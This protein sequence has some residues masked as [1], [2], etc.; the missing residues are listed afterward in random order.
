M[1]GRVNQWVLKVG[2]VLAVVVP[3]LFAFYT[4]QK[5]IETSQEIEKI[6]LARD[7]VKDFYLEE[8]RTFRNIRTA[9]ESCE[10]LY[11]EYKKGGKFTHDEINQYL[12]FF[13]D[14]GFYYRE[15]AL[16]LA[17]I[18]Q[19]FGAYIIE[20][21]ENDE[22]RRYIKELQVNAKQKTAF[23]HFQALSEALEKLP[24]RKELT[25]QSRRSCSK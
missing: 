18:N 13:D 16:D 14:V 24:E 19:Q 23:V 10:Q 5:S 4:F 2:S 6:N 21:S 7:L 11:V 9:V 12:G 25:E 17:I 20:A 8:A 15:G 22:L 3:L 1:K